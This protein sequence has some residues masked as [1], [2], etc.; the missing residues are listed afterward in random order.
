VLKAKANWP[1][2][3]NNGETIWSCPHAVTFWP[4]HL[5]RVTTC[6]K[7]GKHRNVRKLSK[8]QG[9]AR[10]KIFREISNF[11]FGATLVFNSIVLRSL[12]DAFFAMQFISLL[13]LGLQGRWLWS[14]RK[15]LCDF[16]LV[17]NGDLGPVLPRFRDIAGFLW[18]ATPPLFH[19]NFTGVFPLD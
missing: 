16:L 17:I 4:Q 1:I 2:G 7:T 9:N 3:L 14:N 12:G 10:K 6:L 15:R 5:R 18:R 19:P 11:T 13:L 8:S